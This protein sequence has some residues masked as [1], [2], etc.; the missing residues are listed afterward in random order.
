M[1]AKKMPNSELH[2]TAAPSA[3]AGSSDA[4]EGRE[5]VSLDVRR[6]AIL[7]DECLRI[8]RQRKRREGGELLRVRQRFLGATARD[9]G[10]RSNPLDFRKCGPI[11]MLYT[12][13]TVIS[14]DNDGALRSKRLTSRR[15]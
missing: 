2:R 12:P 14:Y 6:L 7:Y 4:S 11:L 10:S 15:A 9:A 8:L 1:T 13:R 5:S 3:A